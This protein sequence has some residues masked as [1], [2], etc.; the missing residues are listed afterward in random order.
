MGTLLAFTTVA[1]S[2]L[3]LRY[4]PPEE[5]PLVSSL[6]ESVAVALQ[7]HD[8]I[9]VIGIETSKIPVRSCEDNLQ[10]LLDEETL[11]RYPLVKKEV[12][13]GNLA[14]DLIILLNPTLKKI[15]SL[16]VEEEILPRF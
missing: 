15:S 3:I 10:P 1:I 5:V 4:V 7:C 11:A 16:I 9:P 14:F 8:N 6:Q 13:Q 2:V 12:A